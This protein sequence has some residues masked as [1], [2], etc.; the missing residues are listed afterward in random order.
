[1]TVE[2][3]LDQFKRATTNTVRAL[4]ERKDV[5]VG[6]SNEPSGVVG[7]RAKVPSPTL[8]MDPVQLAVL[9]GTAD[10]AAL[11]LRHHDERIH[12]ARQPEGSEAQAAFDALE[13]ARVEALGAREMAG[14]AQNL[15]AALEQKYQQQGFDRFMNAADVPRAE[16][17]RLL[18]REALTGAQP[19]A[20]ARSA[21]NLVRAELEPKLKTRLSR[22]EAAL[23]SQSR[24]AKVVQELLADLRL[25]ERGSEKPEE[26]P[27]N[28]QEDV[29]EEQPPEQ[30]EGESDEG[31]DAQPE[32]AAE[33]IAPA[34]FDDSGD[35]G[36]EA[37]GEMMPGDGE[38]DD[39][40][41]GAPPRPPE[42]NYDLNNLPGYHV[43]SRAFDEVIGAEQL[44]EPDE[45]SRLRELL[46]RQLLPLQGA[47]ARL[48]NRLQR[49]LLAKQQRSWN[50]D[51]EEGI[52]D[53]ARLARIV[54]NPTTPLS[55]KRERDTDFRDTVVSLLIDNSGSMRGRPISIAA[56]SADILARTLERCAVKVEIL[57]FTTRAWKGGRSREL[58]VQQGKPVNPGRL[59]DLRHIV[60]KPADAPWR[61]ARRALGVMLRE[62]ILK[63]NIDGEALVWAHERLM[64]RSEQRRILMVISDGAPVD[65]ATLSVNSGNYLETHLRHV[66]EW[67]ETRSPVELVAIGI[68]HDVTRYYRRAVTI[69]DAE[70]LGG[71]MMEKL[72]EL[73]DET[74]VRK[75]LWA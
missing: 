53:A 9:R 54:A 38:E 41:P 24:F 52:L 63:E 5:L 57:G 49:R 30:D 60:Y 4:A 12:A 6:F 2:T 8:N 48:A 66:I 71:T 33:Q 42:V 35:G 64:A 7:A 26:E 3:P 11:R 22:L 47:I 55:F 45:I 19:P 18:L 21:V 39:P 46:D 68:G 51:L 74:P 40:T 14:V 36:T 62:G 31:G 17:L 34:E 10:A 1:M 56:L 73:F 43:F 69:V 58:W 50:F 28:N 27:E 20:A 29:G 15:T 65:D 70:Q 32:A 75:R 44:A 37:Q 72:A 25:D 23:S 13:Q 61:R 16:A 59:N 67:I